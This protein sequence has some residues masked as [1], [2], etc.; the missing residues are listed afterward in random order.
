MKSDIM[1]ALPLII[2]G[3]GSLLLLLLEVF[4]KGRWQ[5]AGATVLILV[6]ALF[7]QLNL[8]GVYVNNAKIFSGLVY[9]DAYTCFLNMLILCAS[10]L[11][12]LLGQRDLEAEGVESPAEFYSLMLM[13]SSGAMIFVSAAELITLFLGLELM[14]IAAYCLAGSAIGVRSSSESAIKYFLLGSFAS[15]FMLYGIS[16]IYGLSGST[17]ID[18]IREAISLHGLSN[19][20]WLALSL[21]MFLIGF[22]FK[23][24]LVPFHFWAAD[25]YQGAP[26]GVTA[27]MASVI[28]AAGIGAMLRVIWLV[29]GTPTLASYWIN[30]IQVLAALTMTVGNLCALRQRSLKRMLAFSSVS[31]AGYMMVAFLVPGTAAGGAILY[32]VVA[33]SLMTLGSFGVV[34]AVT[35]QNSAERHPDDITR[36]NGLGASRP[37]LGALMAVFMFGLAGLPPGFSGLVGK[38]YLFNAAVQAGFIWLPVI[39]VLNSAVSCYYY[40]R[41]LVAMYFVE[42][43]KPALPVYSLVLNT[44][45]IICALGTIFFGLFPSWIYG[46]ADQAV[47]AVV[48]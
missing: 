38:F 35:A 32:Y 26:T 24:A 34:L 5:R 41:V 4:V 3:L 2:V 42:N 17:Y 8:L 25:V 27:F 31:H 48:G 19:N 29:F 46:L 39:A 14:S 21:G 6:V 7:S 13:A 37:L 36:F 18:P 15:A 11:A 40:L 33:Y 43:E 16:L 22:A 47:R 28:K 30:T 10:I 20:S 45:L 44:T 12:V 23:I 1:T 9:A